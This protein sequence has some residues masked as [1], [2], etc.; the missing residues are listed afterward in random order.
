MILF[1]IINPEN[2]L[3]VFKED[4]NPVYNNQPVYYNAKIT[5]ICNKGSNDPTLMVLIGCMS[6]DNK[7]WFKID[8]LCRAWFKQSKIDRIH[9]NTYFC[10]ESY[11]KTF[12]QK[13]EVL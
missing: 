7:K 3:Y 8:P 9:N 4:D 12:N 6:Y 1:P 11:P 2:N 13:K 5:G 10:K